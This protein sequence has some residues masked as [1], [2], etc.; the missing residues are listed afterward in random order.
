MQPVSPP[1]EGYPAETRRRA[2]LYEFADKVIEIT[3]AFR[4]I[5]E[6]GYALRTQT[7]ST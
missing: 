6:I 5:E 7:G 3:D 4:R 1:T 2:E